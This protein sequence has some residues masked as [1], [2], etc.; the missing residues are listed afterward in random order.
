[1]YKKNSFSVA[2]L[3]N[4]ADKIKLHTFLQKLIQMLIFKK[5]KKEKVNIKNKVVI[6]IIEKYILLLIS[7][8]VD[9][10]IQRET[11]N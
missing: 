2:I 3:S 10:T 6:L 4:T 8:F 7:S 1:M 11:K 5:N 9:G